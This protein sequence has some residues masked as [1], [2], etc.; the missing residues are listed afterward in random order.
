MSSDVAEFQAAIDAGELDRAIELYRGPFLDAF[1]LKDSP[2]F[3][4]WAEEARQD[5]TRQYQAAL[6]RLAAAAIARQEFAPAIAHAERLVATRTYVSV[7][8]SPKFPPRARAFLLENYVPIGRLRVAGQ[9]FGLDPTGRGTFTIA[10]PG[11]YAVLSPD[12]PNAGVLDG[13]PLD[14]AR[15]LEA[16]PHTF[17]P[18]SP[19]TTLA[20]V[21][22]DAV[23]RGFSPFHPG[24]VQ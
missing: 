13:R 12:G 7:V 1:Y 21:W 6:S 8:D 2:E 9:L 23:E 4:R 17:R 14:Q 22:A 16:G 19:A 24:D 11:R 18:S 5:L 15:V 3:E 10:I 20:V